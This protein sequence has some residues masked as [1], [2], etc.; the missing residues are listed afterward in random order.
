MFIRMQLESYYQSGY[1]CICVRFFPSGPGVRALRPAPGD[2]T[3]WRGSRQR[4]LPGKVSVSSYFIR[5][6]APLHLSNN[7]RVGTSSVVRQLYIDKIRIWCGIA[8]GVQST[9]WKPEDM[10]W[11]EYMLKKNRCFTV[12]TQRKINGFCHNAEGTEVSL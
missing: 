3:V 2:R 9:V 5:N 10:F 4:W 1:T 7:W 6:V 11:W 12:S 8:Y